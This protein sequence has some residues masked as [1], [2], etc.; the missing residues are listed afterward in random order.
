MTLSENVSALYGLQEF[1]FNS[2]GVPLP[3]IYR[4]PFEIPSWERGKTLEWS[5]SNALTLWDIGY[6]SALKLCAEIK[7][8]VGPGILPDTDYRYFN[9]LRDDSREG[10]FLKL[11]GKHQLTDLPRPWP[12]PGAPTHD[13]TVQ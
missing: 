6:N 10:D 9:T 4:L 11:F 12:A 13:R 2:K 7:K 3:K 1:V 8:A 5:H